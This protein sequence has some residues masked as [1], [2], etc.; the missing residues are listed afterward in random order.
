[1]GTAG[2]SGSGGDGAGG[3]GAGGSSGG[4]PMMSAG[5]HKT[6][7][8]KNSP[9]GSSVMY[10]MVTSGGAS[11]R[12]ILRWPTGYDNTKP[13]RLILGFHGAG[14][15]ATDIAGD[16][17]GLAPLSTG[18]TIFV[19]PDAVNKTWAAASDGAFVDEILKQVEADLCIDTTRIMLEGFSQGGAMAY[20]LACK[21]PGVF[22]AAAVHSGGSPGDPPRPTSCSKPIAY[23]SSLGQSENIGSQTSD[24]FAMV[25]GCMGDTVQTLPK[26]PSGGHLCSDYKG[27]L[28]GYPVRWCPYDGGH[29][30]N[31][32]DRNGGGSWMAMEVWKFLSQF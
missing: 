28:P 31:P 27:C 11:R 23:F 25:N 29:T 32:P 2:R 20:D 17:F 19:A 26:A 5:C 30:A 18:T 21:R 1:M 24:F 10:N 9:S 13:H 3:A 8:L 6:P 12:Y 22:R 15:T 16:Y 7:T 4:A 14:G